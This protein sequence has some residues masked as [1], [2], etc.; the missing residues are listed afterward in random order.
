MIAVFDESEMNVALL[1]DN[2]FLDD[3]A[4]IL[5]SAVDVRAHRAGAVHDEREI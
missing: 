1:R 2:D 3:R 5:S 4:N